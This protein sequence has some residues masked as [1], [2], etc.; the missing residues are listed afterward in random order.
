M[1]PQCQTP[2]DL[3]H[4]RRHVARRASTAA[5][6]VPSHSS[7]ASSRSTGS[8]SAAQAGRA[9]WP[10]PPPRYDGRGRRTA[11]RGT[12]ASTRCGRT[13]IPDPPRCS[14]KPSPCAPASAPAR[15]ADCGVAISSS[16][17]R[18]RT[19]SWPVD[20]ERGVAR[21]GPSTVLHTWPAGAIAPASW[22]G[23]G[24]QRVRRSGA[25]SSRW[26]AAARAGRTCGV[27]PS[28]VRIRAS[29]LRPTTSRRGAGRRPRR[30]ARRRRWCSGRWRPAGNAGDA[31][32]SAAG[33]RR[34]TC[35]PGLR[36]H[37]DPAGS[38]CMPGRVREQVAQRAVAVA[39]C[40]AGA[41]R[42]GR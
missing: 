5:G 12:R 17:A 14:W 2:E 7:S 36:S 38:E 19:S 35:R 22:A 20:Q 6:T 42:A 32:S 39:R 16:V 40:R 11:R 21:R 25:R 26:R 34:R 4:R 8:P 18:D 9:R 33:Q 3:L 10:A 1:L 23:S 13:S 29:H 37:H 31:S 41:R 15:D 24:G 30:A 27:I 28:G